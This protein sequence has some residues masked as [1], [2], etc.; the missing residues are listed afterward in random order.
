MLKPDSVDG[1]GVPMAPR[2]AGFRGKRF[3]PLVLPT[4]VRPA[5]PEAATTK[6]NFPAVIFAVGVSMGPKYC[7]DCKRQLGERATRC[8]HCQGENL[9]CFRQQLLQEALRLRLGVA[10]LVP[11]PLNAFDARAVGVHVRFPK[12]YVQAGYLPARRGP[13]KEDL[14]FLATDLFDS[15]EQGTQYW[16]ECQVVGGPQEDN[17][18]M[19]YG[20]R[21]TIHD[22]PPSE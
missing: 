9:V 6:I 20:L 18:E 3:K 7:V 10:K 13:Y 15:L 17:E 1:L 5:A 8:M 19:C 14:P 21:L 2:E 16:V 22:K 4:Q 11:E 12:G